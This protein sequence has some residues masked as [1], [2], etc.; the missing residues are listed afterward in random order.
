ML[1]RDLRDFMDTNINSKA[2]FGLYA[3]FV[4]IAASLRNLRI[5]SGITQKELAEKSHTSYS[6]IARWEKPGYSGYSLSKLVEIADALNADVRVNL[7]AREPVILHA[8]YTN[9]EYAYPTNWESSP[10]V[11]SSLQQTRPANILSFA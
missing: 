3:L 11:I 6:A 4:D 1:S 7:V 10:R 5:A 8:T 2:K 9:S